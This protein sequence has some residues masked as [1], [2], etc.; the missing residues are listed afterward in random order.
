[1]R[2]RNTEKEWEACLMS[3]LFC[4]PFVRELLVLI[5]LSVH[6]TMQPLKHYKLE[7]S[8]IMTMAHGD[9]IWPKSLEESNCV[10]YNKIIHHQ[11]HT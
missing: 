10:M 11:K 3:N 5:M 6:V 9:D 2:F 4:D 7:I 8:K 1:M